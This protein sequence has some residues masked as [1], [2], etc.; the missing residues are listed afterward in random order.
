MFQSVTAFHPDARKVLLTNQGA[1]F[2]D[3]P[4][5]V[6]VQYYDIDT[7]NIMLSR[8]YAQLAFLQAHDFRSHV[9]FF[10]Y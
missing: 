5:G 6:E 7:S 8:S 10:R 2:A 1:M 9:I 4:S 3:L